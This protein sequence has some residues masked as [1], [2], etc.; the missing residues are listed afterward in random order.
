MFRTALAVVA[1]GS[2]ALKAHRDPFGDGPFAYREFKGGFELT[3]KYRGPNGPAGS[4]KLVVG[5][6]I[7]E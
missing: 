1:D 2:G 4:L 5:R 3:S 7:K 6:E